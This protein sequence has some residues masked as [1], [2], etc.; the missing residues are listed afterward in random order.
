MYALLSGLYNRYFVRVPVRVLLLGLDDSGKT[1][2]S[3]RLRLL[4]EDVPRGEPSLDLRACNLSHFK[5][6]HYFG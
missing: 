2:L 1:A 5:F 6:A 3:Q 4:S